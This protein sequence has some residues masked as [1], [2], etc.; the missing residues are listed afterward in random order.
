MQ[1]SCI[2]N[3]TNP[4]SAQTVNCDGFFGENRRQI[5]HTPKHIN[6]FGSLHNLTLDRKN[7][8]HHKVEMLV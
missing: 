3:V 6:S 5:S 4:P 2:I 7:N 8:K 1:V